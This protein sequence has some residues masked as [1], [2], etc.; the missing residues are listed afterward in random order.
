MSALGTL[1]MPATANTE[2]D[3]APVP[4]SRSAWVI[5]RQHRAALGAVVALL[6]ALALYM[7]VTGLQLHHA[8]VAAAR[9]H[10][11]SSAACSLLVAKFNNTGSV[12]ANGYL[13]QAIPALIGAFVGA[14]VLGRELETGTF[15][16]AWTQSFG[17]RRWT[18]AKLLGLGVSVAAVAG[19]L[20]ILFSWY[21]GPY[22]SVGNQRLG[23]TEWPPLAPG[24]FGL[25]GTVFCAW[26]LA[27]FAIGALAGMLLRRVVPAIVA[28]LIAYA[29]LAVA[30]GHSLRPHY[31]A[32]VVT[33]HLNIPG[34]ALV[35]SQQWLDKAGHPASQSTLSQVLERGG[36]LLAGKGG[37]PKSAASWQ[38]LVQHG[39]TQLTTYQPAGRFWAFQFI[40]SG[41]LVALSVLL[42]AAT[43][44]LV[45][46]RAI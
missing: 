10:P 14:P 35:L 37:V 12:L 8:Y 29:A 5:W 41:W 7:W 33:H 15:R 2:P 26:T 23:L 39:Y 36:T 11:A 13:L 38:Y 32:P 46:R 21:Y 9:C 43:L 3:P 30:A 40:E 44:W 34:T 20:S 16:F 1:A 42:A 19:A 27:A 31:L 22:F 18:L 6:G 25:R 17:R 28:T 24:L 45:R 4:W